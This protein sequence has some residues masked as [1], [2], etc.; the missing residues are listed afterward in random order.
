MTPGGAR[1]PRP[2]RPLSTAALAGAGFF[3]WAAA[4]GPAAWRA[5]TPFLRAVGRAPR[6]A[7]DT[8]ALLLGGDAAGDRG[9]LA[10]DLVWLGMHGPRLVVLE[11]WVGAPPAPVGGGLAADLGARLAGIP[12]PRYRRWALRALAAAEAAHPDGR[13]DPLAT[14]F[15]RVPTVLAYAVRPG[16]QSGGLPPELGPGAYTVTLRGGHEGLPEVRIALLPPP[17]LAAVARGLGAVDL[18]AGAAA[19]E[20]GGDWLDGLGLEAARLALGLPLDALRFRWTPSGLASVALAGHH[21]ALDGRGLGLAASAPDERRTDLED[22]RSGSPEAADRFLRGRVVFFRPWPLGAGDRAAFARQERLYLDLMEPLPV[23]RVPSRA[24][25]R[26]L[27]A[28]ILATAAPL[29]AAPL[30]LALPLW[31]APLVASMVLL[32]GVESLAAACL[33]AAGALCVGLALRRS[34]EATLQ[35]RRERRFGGRVAPGHRGRWDALLPPGDTALP[36]AYLALAAQDGPTPGARDA[37]CSRWGLFLDPETGC[38]ALGVAAAGPDA[39]ETLGRAVLDLRRSDGG[40][41]GAL[42]RGTLIFRE[43]RRLGHPTWTLEGPP[44]ERALALFGGAP[45]G[46]FRIAKA[47][48]EAFGGLFEVRPVPGPEGARVLEAIGPSAGLWT[49]PDAGG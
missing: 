24:V 6:P 10:R 43:G 9:A 34:L 3:F 33:L 17:E 41:R 8:A 22:L 47:D 36:A 45:A 11:G 48:A 27:D 31:A 28:A 37:W 49:S 7:A 1:T 30:W 29:A 42:A 20:C 14:A 26:V 25:G 38:G 15:Q 32:G 13:T 18:G 16:I 40:A 39:E 2:P 19:V 12:S 46:A 44:R 4:C 5:A 21:L 23:P 35:A